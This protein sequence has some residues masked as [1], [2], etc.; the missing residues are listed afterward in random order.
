[1]LGTTLALAG[2]AAARHIVIII[3]GPTTPNAHSTPGMRMRF[4]PRSGEAGTTFKGVARGFTPGEY[5]TAWE[6]RGK[7]STQLLGD[8]ATGAGRLTVYRDT[9]AGITPAGRRKLCLQGERSRRIACAVFVVREP[10]ADPAP[11][12]DPAGGTG[13]GGYVP[14]STGPGYVPPGSG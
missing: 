3:L 10:R 11:A 7:R 9:V 14:P 6:F 12:E 8:N 13:G 2:P 5:V 4:T 1:M